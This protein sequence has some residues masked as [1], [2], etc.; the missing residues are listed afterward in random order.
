M[1][2]DLDLL[3]PQI[4]ENKIWDRA[5]DGLKADEPNLVGAYEVILTREL[6]LSNASQGEAGQ[7]NG[8]EQG[9][10]DTRR[11]QMREIIQIG[12]ENTKE[13]IAAKETLGGNLRI[14]PL[15]KALVDKAVKGSPAASIVWAGVCL[16]TPILKDPLDESVANRDG[17]AYVVPRVE[18]SI[19]S[20]FRR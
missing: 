17:T 19:V 10:T 13:E 5:Y 4:R 8:I 11:A 12:E 18:W 3:S 15:I 6:R 14:L 7:E 1:A 20:A 2:S 16:L 9:N